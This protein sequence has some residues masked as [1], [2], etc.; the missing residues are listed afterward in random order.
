[1]YE[2]N[3]IFRWQSSTSAETEVATITLPA[4]EPD[5][6]IQ[7]LEEQRHNSEINSSQIVSKTASEQQLEYILSNLLKYGVLIASAVVLLGG[8]LYLI[9]HGSEPATYQVF[10]GE[11]S[12]FRSPAG[13]FNAVLAGS[14][15]GI[16]Q[17]G[18]LLLIATPVLRVIISLLAFIFKRELT[19]IVVT[20]LVLASL[21]YSLVGAY[22]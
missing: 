12:E 18:L 20:L 10:H 2:F 22:F 16:I 15:R 5:S 3:S 17:L 13:V 7:Q 21:T 1:M 4:E 14:R 8:I 6:D 19:Y 11:P 9:N